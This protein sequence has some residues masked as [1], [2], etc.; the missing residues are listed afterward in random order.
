M[1]AY[2]FLYIVSDWIL[3]NHS[4]LQQVCE[5]R[6]APNA[7]VHKGP[8]LHLPRSTQFK[9]PNMKPLLHGKSSAHDG[10]LSWDQMRHKFAPNFIEIGIYDMFN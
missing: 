3:I 4:L 1:V 6:Y 2:Y 10:L 7:A 5:T 9:Q 8:L